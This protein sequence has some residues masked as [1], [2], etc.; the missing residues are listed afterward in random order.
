MVVM[1]ANHGCNNT[2]YETRLL[3]VNACFLIVEF[4]LVELSLIFYVQIIFVKMY[5][6][7]TNRTKHD[8]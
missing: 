7:F 8:L 5:L 4:M 6:S 3:I 2:I 1:M